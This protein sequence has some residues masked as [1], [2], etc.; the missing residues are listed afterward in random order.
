MQRNF[1]IMQRYIPI[2]QHNKKY[3][4]YM[5]KVQNFQNPEI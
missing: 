3:T 2:I 5:G 1:P 4:E